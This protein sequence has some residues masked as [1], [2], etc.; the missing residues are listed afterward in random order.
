M[1]VQI[2]KGVGKALALIALCGAVFAGFCAWCYSQDMRINAPNGIDEAGYQKIGGIDQW[3]QIR[4]QD[5]NNPVILWLNGGPGLSTVGASY[6]LRA[7]ENRFTIVMWDQRGEGRTF[8]RSGTSVAS[9]MT[10]AQMTQDGIEAASYLTQHLHKNK[11]ILLGHSWGSLLGVHMVHERPDL[12]A[13]YVGTGQ[14]VNLEKDAEAAYP[15]LIKRARE[16]G[17]KR[18][19]QQLLQAGPPPYPEQGPTKWIWVAWANRLD[20]R[21]PAVPRS[22]GAIWWRGMELL[23]EA[24]KGAEFSQT[25]L[26]PSIIKDDLP[27][28]GLRFGMPVVF[29]QGTED[30][31][32]VT[33]LAKNYFDEIE[34]P[35]KR[36]ALI[37]GKGHLAIFM[38]RDQFLRALEDEVRPLALANGA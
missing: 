11:I 18:A 23:N 3:I 36:F 13:A 10:I 1:F 26:W 20:P 31:L 14:L 37:Q 15:L 4:G 24:N 2:A 28:L 12:F 38:G 6:V 27:S 5:R 25:H 8:D 16:L 19:E 30:R 33:A 7:W 21:S 29:I 35:A 9:T 17:N 34:A 32:T 22:F